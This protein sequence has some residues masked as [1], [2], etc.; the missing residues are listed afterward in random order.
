MIYEPARREGEDRPTYLDRFC[1]VNRPLWNAL[2]T[3]EWNQIEN[4]VR[5]SD[6]PE[7]RSGW[8]EVGKEAG[9]SKAREVYVDPTDMYRLYRYEV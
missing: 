3:E 8:I 4:H 9:F 7:T 2:T 1:D 5:S 6:L